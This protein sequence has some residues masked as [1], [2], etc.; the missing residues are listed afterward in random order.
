MQ[1]AM[2]IQVL[3][4]SSRDHVRNEEVRGITRITYNRENRQTKVAMG[5]KISLTSVIMVIEITSMT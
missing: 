5:V 4:V 1:Q 2:E 3:S